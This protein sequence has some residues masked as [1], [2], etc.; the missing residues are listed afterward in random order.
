LETAF[1]QRVFELRL[2]T[3]LMCWQVNCW[4]GTRWRWRKRA[5]KRIGLLVERRDVV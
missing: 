1:L 2:E 4:N 3:Q 5:P